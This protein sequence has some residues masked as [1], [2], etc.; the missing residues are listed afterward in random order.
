MAASLGNLTFAIGLYT[1]QWHL[2]IAA[3]AFNWVFAGALWQSFRARLAYLFDPESRPAIRP[4]TVLGSLIAV[5]A[6]LEVGTLCSLPFLL[7]LGKEAAHYAQ[8]LG[9]G[10]A[11]VVICAVVCWQHNKKSVSIGEIFCI[12]DQTALAPGMGCALAVLAGVALGLVGLGYQHLLATSHWT[13]LSDAVQRS[14]EFFEASPQARKAYA[15]MVIGI[16]PWVEEFLFRGLM[17]RAMWSEWGMTRALL[18]SSFFFAALH[19]MLAWPMVFA[20]GAGSALLF[21]RTRALLPC[22]LMHTSYNAV[23]VWG[24]L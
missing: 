13:E 22:I 11:A 17:F 5:V 18:A 2:A 9:Y 14:R 6:L 21:A 23:V 8:A 1:A 19:P 7:I 16:A 24:S 12:D 20:L 15:I 10:L 3:I 4:P